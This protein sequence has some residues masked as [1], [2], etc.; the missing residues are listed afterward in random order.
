MVA[1]TALP[2]MTP[3]VTKGFCSPLLELM[4]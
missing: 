2:S 3:P 4:I 1:A